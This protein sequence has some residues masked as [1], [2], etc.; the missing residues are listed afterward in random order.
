MDFFQADTHSMRY[1][2]LKEALRSAASSDDKDSVYQQIGGWMASYLM[3]E[4]PDL[5]R[6]GDVCPFT[7]HAARIDTIR[8][9]IYDG[10]LRDIS[11]MVKVMRDACHEVMTMPCPGTMRHFATAI[12]GFPNATTEETLANLLVVQ[13]KLKHHTLLHGLMVGRFHPASE[14][15]GLW[16]SAFRPLR[17]PVPLL[18]VRHLVEN[19]AEFVMR[20]PLLYPTYLMKFSSNAFRKLRAAWQRRR[21]PQTAS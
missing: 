14:V 18:A 6:T 20:Q 9:G 2:T 8:I 13:K 5:G 15:E 4:H 11:A 17:S 1:L 16:N 12:V 21:A 3:K 7:A 10:D 19:D